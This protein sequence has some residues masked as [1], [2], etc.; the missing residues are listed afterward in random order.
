[1]MYRLESS[2]PALVCT[3]LIVLMGTVS[4]PAFGQG[5]VSTLA[6]V[7]VDVSAGVIPGATIGAKNVDTGAA[8][9]TVSDAKGVF[10]LPSMPPGTYEVTTS[11]MG[12]KKNVIPDVKLNVAS[13]STIKVTLEVGGVEE[14]ITVT[15]GADVVQ[16]QSS[17]IA[18]TIDTKQITNLPLV[19][20]DAINAITMLAGVDTASTNRNSTVSGLPRSAINITIDGVNTQDNNNKTTEGLF[21]L[22]SPRLDA[23][24][25]VTVSTATAGADAAGQGAVQI[26][27]ITRS[28][29]N[30][31]QGSAYYYLRDPR[32][33]SNYWF[34][35]RNLPADPVTGSAPRDQV[36]LSQPGF[37]E[38]GPI[39][40]DKAFFFFNFEEFRL[41]SQITRNR[42][43]LTPAAMQGVFTY[44]ITGGTRQVNLLQLAAANGQTAT[45]DPTVA[46]VMSDILAATAT[47]GGLQQLTDPNEQRYTFTNSAQGLRYF[48]TARLD[49]NIAK[50]HRASFSYTRQNFSSKPDTLN[51][52]DPTFPGFPIIGS[53]N[54]IRLTWASSIRS[55][56]SPNLVNEA[57]GGYTNSLVSFFPEITGDAFTNASVGN[58]GPYSLSFSGASGNL[59]NTLTNPVPSRN[60]QGRENPTISI[61]DTM[62]WL[63]GAHSISFGGSFTHV[64][65]HSYDQNVVPSI[66]LGLPTG[67]PA[68]AMFSAANFPG[69]S[70]TNINAARDL[71]AL[72]TGH[73]SAITSDARLNEDTNQYQYLGS[74]IQR[75]QMH[76]FGF[77]V[78]DSWRARKN[79]TVNAGVR[80]E[81][82]LPFVARNNNYSQ[83]TM[84]DLYGISGLNNLFKPGTLTGQK[85]VLV[86][87]A[88]DVYSFNVDRNNFAPSI[89]MTWRPSAR[90]G[91]LGRLIGGDEDTVIRGAY[92]IAFNRQGIGDYAGVYNSNPGAVTTTSRT[93]GLGNLG[94]V[95][96]LLRDT[97]RLSVPPFAS[98]AIY[99]LSPT[100][101]DSV[102]IFDPNIETPYTHSFTLGVQR[103]LSKNM[104]FEVRYVGTRN[105]KGWVTNNFNETNIKENGFI[106]EFRRAQANLQANILAGRGNSFAYFGPNTGTSPLPIYLAYFSA[107]PASQAGDPTKYNSGNFTSTNFTNPL[108]IFSPAPGTPAGTN[109]TTGLAGDPQ[110]QANAILA[111]LP[112]NFF[113][114]NPDVL[115]GAN[116]TQSTAF[117]QY[118]A[119]QIEL[120]RRLS[121]GLQVG[122]NYVLANAYNSTFYSLRVPRERTFSTGNTGGIHQALKFNWVYELPFGEGKRFANR[123]GLLNR[124]AGGWGFDGNARI[125]TGQILSFGNVRLVGMTDDDLRSVFKVRKD[126]ANRI[127]YILPQDI[128]DNT[129]KAFS[130]SATS[131]TGYGSLGAPSGRYFAPA[132]GPDC[133]QIV[134]GDC[135]PR[136]HF[137][138]GPNFVRVDLS[139]SK[140]IAFTRGLNFEFRADFLNALNNINFL[141]VTGASNSATMGQ[142]TSAYQDANNTQD[143]GG[144]LVQLGFRINW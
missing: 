67:D 121:R 68:L 84:A 95:P 5:A 108:A 89:G 100:T 110:R 9:S 27:F 86:A 38:G 2:V 43:I 73:V 58:M 34:N 134:S 70:T 72:L 113:R 11:L 19:S 23:I 92:A 135:A 4:A 90:N 64:G 62:N 101:A 55:T 119:L 42:T 103:E 81:L 17:T 140:R 102:N 45:L 14:V 3:A 125:Q 80:Y 25:E 87:Y 120:R 116:M 53:Q 94:A 115:G 44:P 20:R 24:E 12:F 1:M 35:N 59:G 78:Q 21:S 142:V 99:P 52:A 29:T 39:V 126:D 31:Y 93:S 65:L 63:R 122:G 6:G 128:I 28:G 33:N 7:V 83:A 41:P 132:N 13:V 69:A 30:K 71:Y 46:K 61:E 117:G 124:I 56:L 66:T 79:V 105:R 85:P 91:W 60:T 114:A 127:V 144:R 109:A 137:V 48:P 50:N 18:T 37:R 107:V 118:D 8:F 77:F 76:E 22:I 82:Q 139:A 15:G 141:G 131:A 130:T 36:K 49:Y 112:A 104:A 74:L 10:S 106:D 51:G 32:W 136:E 98:T 143:P 123:S 133:I 97:S 26:K 88:P 138:T 40:H 16:T 47:T 54:S 111:G 129:I 57:H 75:G 96:L